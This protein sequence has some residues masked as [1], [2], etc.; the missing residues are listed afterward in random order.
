VLRQSRP[1][2]FALIE[3]QIQEID[4]LVEQ[5]R[6]NLN[7]NSMSMH[8]TSYFVLLNSQQL[9]KIYLSVLFALSPY[10]C[11]CFQ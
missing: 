5:G 2:E 8:V 6:T 11:S 4:A 7:W 9:W 10:F 1:V 3:V